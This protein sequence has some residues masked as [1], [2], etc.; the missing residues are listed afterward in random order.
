MSTPIFTP[1]TPASPIEAPSKFIA[2]RQTLYKTVC[3]IYENRETSLG[4]KAR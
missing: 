1:P 4:L 2:T 3:S